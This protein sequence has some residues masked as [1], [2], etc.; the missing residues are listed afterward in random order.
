MEKYAKENWI[1]AFQALG[2]IA[3][4]FAS[5]YL[6]SLN[7]ILLTTGIDKDVL[8]QLIQSIQIL[9]YGL[10]L[11]LGFIVLVSSLTIIKNRIEAINTNSK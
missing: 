7:H 10:G 5:R 6:P 1:L 2:V 11:V 9:S 8:E 3:I 4:F